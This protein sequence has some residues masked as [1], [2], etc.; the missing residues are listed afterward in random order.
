VSGDP[1]MLYACMEAVG[2]PT[3]CRH[4]RA[5]GLGYGAMPLEDIACDDRGLGIHLG[6]RSVRYLWPDRAMESAHDR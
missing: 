4:C 3:V 2:C 1:E 5:Q 6:A